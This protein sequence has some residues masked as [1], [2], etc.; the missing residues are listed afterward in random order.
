MLAALCSWFTGGFD[1]ADLQEA[2]VLLEEL[3]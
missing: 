1:A 2:K 3:S